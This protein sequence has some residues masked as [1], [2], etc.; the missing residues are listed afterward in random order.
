MIVDYQHIDQQQWERLI[1]CSPTASW[2]QTPQAYKFLCEVQDELIPFCY[3]V[4][5]DDR[6]KGV[7]V[8]YVVGNGKTKFGRFFTSRAVI[9]GGPLLDSNITD[10]ELTELLNVVANRLKRKAIYIETRNF[11]DYSK[12]KH[13][14]Q[15]CDFQYVPHY[16]YIQ[17]TATIES[18]MYYDRHHNIRQ[19]IRNGLEIKIVMPRDENF[20]QTISD[21]YTLLS[22]LYKRHL[23]LPVFSQH[24]FERLVCQDD[25]RFFVA[26]QNGK[27]VGG[28]LCVELRNSTLYSWYG[29]RDRAISGVH[30]EVFATYKAICWARDN[31]IPWFDFMGAGTPEQPYG[32]REFKARFGGQC[33]EYGRFLV[34]NS[35]LRY[36][37]GKIGIRLMQKL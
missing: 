28:E 14:F 22:I 4:A 2:F 24:F 31:G 32:V 29:C 19:S 1:D 37:L 12:W 15:K 25:A 21:F 33:V 16:N 8:G 7:C 11:S 13:V 35:P 9:N 23:H 3:G 27:V 30:P 17:P 34:V 26:L 6:L 10:N 20:N 5:T 36:A 18:D